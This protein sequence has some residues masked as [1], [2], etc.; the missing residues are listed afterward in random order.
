MDSGTLSASNATLTCTHLLL[1]LTHSLMWSM[2]QC[3][4]ADN[5]AARGVAATFLN[6][7]PP[8]FEA[9]ARASGLRDAPMPDL[10]SEPEGEERRAA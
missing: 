8:A 9:V 5:F 1:L 3:S 2:R 10:L 6:V 7:L 4:Q